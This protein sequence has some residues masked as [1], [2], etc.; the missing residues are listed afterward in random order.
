VQSG[1]EHVYLYSH[2]GGYDAPRNIRDAL[3]RGKDRWN[4]CSYLTRIIFRQLG[5]GSENGNTGF[6][7]WASMM[8]NEHPI[9]VIDCDTQ[10][11]SFEADPSA[12]WLN[13]HPLIGKSWSFEDYCALSDKQVDSLFDREQTET[14]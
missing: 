12:D 1:G 4:D 11:V 14:A 6:G 13:D 2:W 8:D 10:T 9:P 7:I 3:I 5:A